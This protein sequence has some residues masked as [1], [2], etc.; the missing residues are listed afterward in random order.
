MKKIECYRNNKIVF[1]IEC[2]IRYDILI[3]Q[4]NKG[5]I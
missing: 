5:I 1:T 3:K 2:I 4:L